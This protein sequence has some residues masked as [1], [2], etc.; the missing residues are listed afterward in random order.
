MSIDTL[1]DNLQTKKEKVEVGPDPK[2]N[3][4]QCELYDTGPEGLNLVAYS[5]LKSWPPVRE[6]AEIWAK[7]YAQIGTNPKAAVYEEIHTSEKVAGCY[8][9]F[10]KL[11]DKEQQAITAKIYDAWQIPYVRVSIEGKKA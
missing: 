1:L 2:K 4:C 3:L 5:P 11:S 10:S 8:F 9:S 7:N 6:T